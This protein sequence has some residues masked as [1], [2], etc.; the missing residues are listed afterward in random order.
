MRQGQ[1]TEPDGGEGALADSSR[2][3]PAVGS[4]RGEPPVQDKAGGRSG[5]DSFRNLTDELM[6]GPPGEIH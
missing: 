6:G 5:R 4:V 3:R 1:D 2:A